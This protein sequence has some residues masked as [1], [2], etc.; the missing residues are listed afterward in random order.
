MERY[1]YFGEDDVSTTGEACMFSLSSFLGM[2][3]A[4]ATS[5]TMHF[6]ARNGTAADD[7]VTVT[8]TGT[9]PKVFM[10][11][12]VKWMKA[13]QRNPFIIVHDGESGGSIGNLPNGKKITSVA[14]ATVA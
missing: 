12:I 4:G 10:T 5:T 6:Q 14:V 1:F 7:V 11:E 8:H 13:N 3:P 2:Q 9:T